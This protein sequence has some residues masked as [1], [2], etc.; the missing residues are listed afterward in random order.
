MGGLYRWGEARGP[1][2]LRK[3]LQESIW[4]THF[5]QNPIWFA[6]SKTEIDVDPCDHITSDAIGQPGQRVFYIQALQAD[7]THTVIIEKTQLQS[8]AVGIEQFLA[9]VSRQNPDLEEASADYVE[10]HMR[11]NP[12]VDP[13]FRVGEIGLGYDQARDRVVLFVREV[14]AEAEGSV[15]ES[16]SESG[17]VYRFWCTRTQLRR[18]ARWGAEIASRGR[19]VCRQCGQPMEPEGHFCPKKNGH[20]H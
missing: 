12:P 17:T 20:M 18:L 3:E 8:L 19:P 2:L 1:R 6:M 14:Q 10:E 5:Q 15:A 7:K 9:E 13:A 11:I 4:Y 16:E